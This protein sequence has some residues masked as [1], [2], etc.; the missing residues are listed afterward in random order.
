MNRPAPRNT[1]ELFNLFA[2]Y[3]SEQGLNGI[4]EGLDFSGVDP[5]QIYFALHSRAPEKRELAIPPP[6]FS[7]LDRYVRGFLSDEFRKNLI[8][9]FLEAFP[10]KQRLLFIHIPKTAG[11][12]LSARLMGQYP[13]LNSQMLQPGWGTDDQLCQ[14]I[15]NAVVGLASSDRLFIAGHNTVERYRT[16][17]AIRH[18][19]QLFG[20]VRDP[21]GATISQVNYILTRIFVNEAQA[22]PD[23][24]GWR[25]IFQIE[26]P[27]LNI[28]KAAT[29][30]LAG[31][32]LRNQGVVPANVACRFLGGATVE[33]ALDRIICYGIE[34]TDTAHLDPWCHA[35]WGIDRHTKSNVSRAYIGR[36]DLSSADMQHMASI[37]AED[38]K[39]YDRV[40]E[41]IA[42]LGSLS[43]KGLQFA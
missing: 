1:R 32:I 28:G 15:R 17:R 4:F 20:V 12:E 9:R 30:E 6:S 18:E 14:E 23:T 36:D 43:V 27:D 22:R 37:T 25:R 5:R 8:P 11:S 3:N 10:E 34:L 41:R 39:L 35:K 2:E 19:D 42:R 16:W 7:P 26:S 33:A 24:L 13:F 38:A 29:I 40:Q 31:R 21:I